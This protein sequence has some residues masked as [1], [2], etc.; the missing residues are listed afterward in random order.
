[1]ASPTIQI[2][3]NKKTREVEFEIVGMPGV[4]CKDLTDVLARGHQQLDERLTEDW[5]TPQ[6]LPATI[7]EL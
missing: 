5:Y 4:R 6:E 7:D 1:M 3:I 2:I